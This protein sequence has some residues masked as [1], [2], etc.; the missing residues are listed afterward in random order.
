M[1]TA[2]VGVGV[3]LLFE[4]ELVLPPLDPLLAAWAALTASIIE[5]AGGE[6]PGP[7]RI[8]LSIVEESVLVIDKIVE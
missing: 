3:E 2:V 5:P 1:A 7:V 4:L 8:F 6:L